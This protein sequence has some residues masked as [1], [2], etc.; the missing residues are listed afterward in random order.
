MSDRPCTK[1]RAPVRFARFESSGKWGVF[2]EDAEETKPGEVRWV[3][4]YDRTGTRGTG[5][6][7]RRANVGELGRLS[8]YATCEY[9]D[10][11]RRR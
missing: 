8:H 1:C 9:A 4:E 11:F 3:L 5:R 6:W 7:A 10:D 2:D